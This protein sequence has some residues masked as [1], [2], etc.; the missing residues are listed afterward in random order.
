MSDLAQAFLERWTLEN[1]SPTTAEA[2]AREAERL[3][4]LCKTEA[5]EEGFSEAELNE[6]CALSSDDEHQDIVSF[7]QAAL[8]AAAEQGEEVDEDDEDDEG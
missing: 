8:E 6:A 4:E 7:M 2:D 1:I 3:A 5:L